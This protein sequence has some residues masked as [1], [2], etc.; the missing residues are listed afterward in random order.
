VADLIVDFE[1]E[2]SLIGAV[3]SGL[4]LQEPAS[5]RILYGVEPG[6]FFGKEHREAWT[7]LQALVNDRDAR[8]SDIELAWRVF[9]GRASETQR[10][11]LG[12]LLLQGVD[13][14][15][16]PLQARVVEMAMRR[17]AIRAAESVIRVA[18]DLVVPPE[19]VTSAAN[20]AFL[21]VAR[22]AGR[23]AVVINSGLDIFERLAEGRPFRDG[24]HSGDRLGRL[25]IS[26]VDDLI[27]FTPGHVILTGAGPGG[28]KTTLG[29]QS[30]IETAR[31]GIP[32]AFISLE[33]DDSEIAAKIASYYTGIP[34]RTLRDQGARALGNLM[35][36]LRERVPE[37]ER[38]HRI[39]MPAYRPV[40]TVLSYAQ[41]AVQ[42]HGVRFVVIDYF[43]Y[44]GI[45]KVKGGN[46]SQAYAENS[47]AIKAFT[48]EAR[49]VTHLLSQLN[50]EGRKGG[51]PKLHDFKE[52]GQLEQDA[53]AAWLMW[54][55]GEK[56][57]GPLWG[58]LAKNRDGEAGFRSEL[59]VNWTAGRMRLIE[60]TT[61]D[62]WLDK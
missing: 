11:A 9:G 43:Q 25:G 21:N 51:E 5:R 39:V 41:E 45:Q 32:S 4:Q 17:A 40:G 35:A 24:D 54:R 16:E 37:F 58:K 28:G 2:A 33:M 15:P 47:G 10:L 59:G 42:L 27:E 34:Y 53:S 30:L 49:C 20:Q 3:W 31:M 18:Q 44:I 50:R 46:D 55:Q 1:A 19:E 56:D 13:L 57:D 38:I 29:I 60:R 12:E 52:T 6:Q 8:L 61:E 14:D 48:Q 36:E 26:Q 7:G 22:G 62:P 23:R